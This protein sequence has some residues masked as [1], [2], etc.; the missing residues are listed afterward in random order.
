LRRRYLIAPDSRTSRARFCRSEDA[1]TAEAIPERHH[2][3]ALDLTERKELEVLR[4]V[5]SAAGAHGA[6]MTDLLLV[7][8]VS[9]ARAERQLVEARMK[10]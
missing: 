2:G 10:R 5:R 3:A 9:A 7:L 6:P 1:W 4:D 8:H